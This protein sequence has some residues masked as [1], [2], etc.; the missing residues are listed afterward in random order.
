MRQ[1]IATSALFSQHQWVLPACFQLS[2]Y[3][4]TWVYFTAIWA[5]EQAL[6]EKLMD[7]LENSRHSETWSSHAPIDPPSPAML[8]F[9]DDA[10]AGIAWR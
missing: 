2:F 9:P 6:L 5:R 4:Q 7:W 8:P 10:A 1:T 3:A